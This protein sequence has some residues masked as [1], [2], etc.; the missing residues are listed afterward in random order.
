MKASKDRRAAA[1]PA[2]ADA[3]A[4]ELDGDALAAVEVPSDFGTRPLPFY[5]MRSWPR[6]ADA[7]EVDSGKAGPPRER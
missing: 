4:P 6:R 7:L 1:A 3:N 2:A 5:S